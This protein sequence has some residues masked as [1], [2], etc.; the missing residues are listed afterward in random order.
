MPPDTPSNTP[1]VN[2]PLFLPLSPSPLWTGSI[3]L[4][5]NAKD[6]LSITGYV[7]AQDGSYNPRYPIYDSRTAT[8]LYLPR[9]VFVDMAEL[10]L[11]DMAGKIPPTVAY[12]SFVDTD[13]AMEEAG[14]QLLVFIAEAT[15]YPM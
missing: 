11:M 1:S 6:H 13:A 3:T 4:S 5:L 15:I 12:T 9:G 10:R 8:A 14:P 7:S 2:S